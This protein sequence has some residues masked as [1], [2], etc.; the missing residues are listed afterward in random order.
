MEKLQNL[1]ETGQLKSHQAEQHEIRSHLETAKNLLNDAKREAN[2]MA[3]RFNTAY[4]AGHSLLMA[5][6]KLRGYRPTQEKGHRSILYSTLD[7]TLPAAASAKGPLERA[8]MQR[9]RAEYDGDDLDV[10]ESQ[11]EALIKAVENVQEE[12]V[13]LSKPFFNAIQK[14]QLAS[15]STTTSPVSPAPAPT[16]APSKPRQQGRSR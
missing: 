3:G 4:S 8:H 14:Q 5:A 11:L 6:I 2:S 9:N 7:Q 12:V 16:P 15:Q 1:V 13:L 10:T